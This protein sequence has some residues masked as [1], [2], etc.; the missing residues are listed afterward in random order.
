MKIEIPC[1]KIKMVRRELV[2]ANS[3]NPNH[4]SKEKMLL[5]KQSI[6][7]NGFCFPIVV[8][9]DSGKYIIID[10]FHRWLIAGPDWLDMEEVPV[11]ILEHDI[12]KRMIA[13][14]QF[15]KARGVHSLD[16]DADLIKDLTDQGKSEEEMCVS[17]GIEPEALHRYKQLTGILDIF[18]DKDYSKSWN[19]DK[20]KTGE[21]K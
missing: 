11:V 4:V 19:I 10:G 15:N 1:L 3:Y 9:E 18:K 13:T 2:T 12:S 6:I 21:T 16:A 17:L 5:L 8:I 20:P 14:V 7:D